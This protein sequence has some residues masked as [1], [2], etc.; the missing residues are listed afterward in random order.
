MSDA[1]PDNLHTDQQALVDK[2]LKDWTKNDMARTILQALHNSKKPF[3][4]D[5]FKVL[6][7]VRS[8]KK[9][10]LA[11][12]AARALKIIH[13]IDERPKGTK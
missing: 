11:E 4:A 2:I 9:E 6:R 5:H 10:H 8:T 12:N 1:L 7:M 3:A 13:Q